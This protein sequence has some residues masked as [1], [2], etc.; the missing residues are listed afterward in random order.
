[1]RTPTS[2]DYDR[3]KDVY[4]F[5]GD[6][7]A[8]AMR[9][10]EHDVDGQ[11]NAEALFGVIGVAIHRGTDPVVT[12]ANLNTEAT[13]LHRFINIT[14]GSKAGDAAWN[15]TD[16]WT[17][18]YQNAYRL[19]WKRQ[20]L[21]WQKRHSTGRY[22]SWLQDFKAED[23]SRIR[24]LAMR[25][26]GNVNAGVIAGWESQFRAGCPAT[27]GAVPFPS[28]LKYQEGQDCSTEANAEVACLNWREPTTP[29]WRGTCPC[30]HR[31]RSS[32]TIKF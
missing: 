8:A 24:D 3:D 32:C 22:R 26:F 23:Y 9:F 12:V 17:P 14:Q 6:E 30:A 7:P 13:K 19:H 20:L 11:D 2:G 18:E 25:E 15:N 31:G 10:L 28:G 16:F 21:Q 29:I 5:S 4:K 27:P 1:M